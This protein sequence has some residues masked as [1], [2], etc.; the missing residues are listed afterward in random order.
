MNWYLLAF[1]NYA[2]FNGRAR[3]KEYWMYA[4][5]Q[6]LILLAFST[7]MGILDLPE[8][9]I[10]STLLSSL[11]G[12]YFLGSIVPTISLAVR[13]MHDIDKTGS[14]VL[15]YFIPFIGSIWFLILTIK[16]GTVGK[17]KYGPDPKKPYD[18]LDAIGVTEE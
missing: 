15:I 13:R 12:L 9:S 6:I 3:R 17:N 7:F 2:T 5:F 11:L 16:E 10:F 14:H 1:K 8:E 18:E 4:L